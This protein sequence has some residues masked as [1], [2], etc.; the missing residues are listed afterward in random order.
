M[1][2]DLSKNIKGILSSFRVMHLM[3][4]LLF[5]IFIT[6]ILYAIKRGFDYTDEAFY[7][8]NF[9]KNQE[10]GISASFFGILLKSFDLS[11][12]ELRII[13]LLLTI[14]SPIA[15]FI[16]I[17]KYKDNSNFLYKRHYFYFFFLMLFSSLLNFSF[18]Y[19]IHIPTV[20]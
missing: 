8:L 12:F 14:T 20:S 10:I 18:R 11:I 15:L 9:S 4:F 16:A 2:R 1:N 5:F 3:T 17:T 19:L 13:R 6:L 7:L